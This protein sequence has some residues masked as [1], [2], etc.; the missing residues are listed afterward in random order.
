LILHDKRSSTTWFLD[1]LQQLPSRLKMN[2]EAT[3]KS[4]DDSKGRVSQQ[5]DSMTVED[6]VKQ[7]LSQVLDKTPE[8]LDIIELNSGIDFNRQNDG[9]NCGVHVCLNCEE[10]L[11]E[12]KFF[13]NNLNIANERKRV[14]KN[15]KKLVEN[16]N[17]DFEFRINQSNIQQTEI[18][19]AAQRK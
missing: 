16:D 19:K 10:F 12:D 18:N 1:S 17:I 4:S 6:K 5:L 8:S 14:L 13:I 15:L 3:Y 2:Y 11:L 7:I 9:V